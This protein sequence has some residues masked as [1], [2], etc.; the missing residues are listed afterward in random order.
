MP[1][2]RVRIALPFRL[3]AARTKSL[4][5]RTPAPKRGHKKSIPIPKI[6]TL[7]NPRGTTLIHAFACTL[8]GQSL[9]HFLITD[10]HRLILTWE[11]KTDDTVIPPQS[12]VQHATPR[13][14]HKSLC[15]CLPPPGSSLY[16]F[17]LLLLLFPVFGL[18]INLAHLFFSVNKEKHVTQ[19]QRH[20]SK[21]AAPSFND[22][23]FLF[24]TESPHPESNPLHHCLQRH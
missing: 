21:Q 17:L 19:K 7:K 5:C 14:V 18:L 13:P 24:A 22:S 23:S 1:E 20:G 8:P 2:Q 15:C 3:G 11:I 4:A 9:A 16:A 12:P 6:E 10:G